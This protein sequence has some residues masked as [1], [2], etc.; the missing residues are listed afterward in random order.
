MKGSEMSAV[1]EKHPRS[2][3]NFVALIEQQQLKAGGTLWF[4]GAGKSSYTLLPTLYRPRKCRGAFDLGLLE[5][6][7]MMRFRQ[8]SMPFLTHSLADDWDMLFFMQHYGVP[9]RLLDWT[10]NPFIGLY[11]AVMSSPFSVKV[12]K[13]KPVFSFSSDAAVWVLNPVTWNT[14]ALKY[15]K[16]DRGILTPADEALQSYKPL[17]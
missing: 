13:G 8:R 6:Q 7:L 11:F 17:T 14:H 16:F 4:R 1:P 12:K 3:K 10:E 9:T 15:Q 5:R 2:F